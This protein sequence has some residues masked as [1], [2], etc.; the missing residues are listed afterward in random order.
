MS[1]V[2]DR[3]PRG[4]V[5]QRPISPTEW[6]YLAGARL[7]PP[8]TIQLFVEGRAGHG[9]IG[10]GTLARAVAAASAACPGAR[11]VRRGRIW[12]DSGLTPRVSRVAV[13][14]G[15]LARFEGPA[16]NQALRRQLAPKAGPSCEVLLLEGEGNEPSTLVFRA[17]HGVMDGKG[18]VAWAAEVFKAL[19]GEPSTPP[20]TEAVTDFAL[21]GRLGDTGRRPRTGVAWPPALDIRGSRPC[22]G[23]FQFRRRAVD[24]NQPGLVAKVASVLAASTG[25]TAY[26][27]MVP[28]DLRPHD[29]DLR[30]TANLT[31]PVFLDGHAGDT[32]E[33]W[34]ERL[35]KALAERTEV[36]RGQA[37]LL[38]SAVPVP[39]L[40][41][42]LQAA[43]ALARR[44][45]RYLASAV[46]SHLGRLDLAVFS[47]GEFE[48]LTIYSP[49]VHAPLVPISV[50]SVESP[51]RTELI[52]SC[53]AG[54][55]ITARAEELL[56]RITGALSP[57][58][59]RSWPG[60]QTY[61]LYRGPET[62]TQLLRERVKES[63]DAVA[64]TSPTGE[65]T[66]AQLDQRADAV[67]AELAARGLGRGAVVG[68][69]TDRSVEAVAGLW[70]TLKAGAAYLPLDPRHP[71]D[72]IGWV[73]DDAQASVCLVQRPYAERINGPDVIVLDDLPTS[74]APPA[75]P[76]TAGPRD[77]VYVIYTSGST[78]RPKGVQIEHHN[79]VNYVTWA[80]EL[81]S[82]DASTRFALFTSLAFD[83][84]GT[85][86]F[87]PLLA[88]GSVA[89]ISGELTPVTLR[90]M[91]ERSGANALKLTPAHLD[92]IGR[93]GLAPE[94]FRILVVGGE[95]LK[96]PV[97]DQAQRAFG[98]QCRIVN[99]Y[100]PTEATIGCV[101]HT[102]DPDRDAAST[103]VPIGT[104]VANTKVYLLGPDRQ[105][106]PAG[107]V[108]ELY[109]TGAQLARGYLGRPDLDRERFV[110]LVDGA[111]A[112]RTG[113]LARILPS[114]ALEC[115][116]RT[117]DQVTLRGHRVEPGEIEAVLEE[118]P[119]VARAL[120]TVRVGSGGGVLCGYVVHATGT[121]A[122]TPPDV[123]ELHE[124]LAVRLPAYMVP[125]ALISVPE[126][127][128]TV[129]GKIDV[130]ALPY[131]FADVTG[132]SGQ[133]TDAVLTP[134]L[135]KME[136]QVAEI[137][138]RLLKLD[139]ERIALDD[140]FHRLG[141]DSLALAEMFAGV[142]AEVVCGAGAEN[143]LAQ[144][145][146]MIR[147]P[148]L[149][150]V[151]HAARR[152]CGLG[153]QEVAGS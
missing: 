74:G 4:S 96:G 79:L 90:D 17:F 82:V 53:P 51:G 65:V 77:L 140:D 123:R 14:A 38:A 109:L 103:A 101:V 18:V 5:F 56:D 24:G 41:R 142:A 86:I 108:G 10:L 97:A 36:T 43:S 143:F 92:L 22:L 122:G 8:F 55:A 149:G 80:S 133:R 131:P 26:R 57:T 85:S 146:E 135:D 145:R 127:P 61:S 44:R 6:L 150:Y 39:A 40:T 106:V 95:R 42:G 81:Y 152:A 139:A 132:T 112:Y 16:L 73:L 32:W 89:L 151:C 37:E 45:N 13:P 84:T 58:A 60:N 72:R 30:S 7:A 11:L 83:L 76:G 88:G 19:R 66:Y 134:R 147:N 136:E 115:L 63:P 100:G 75:P 153:P 3:P 129:N 33:E 59:A 125:A 2:H 35:L 124:H 71:D 49:P 1:A 69:L 126:L 138:A 50:V 110:T 148:T 67:A 70:G 25:E 46:V 31:L 87:L 21:A 64:L 91:L 98:P 116:G 34:H 104:P 12:V 144:L 118:H 23:H 102:Y 105:H 68:L 141:G 117:D 54:E 114:G 121:A 111:L 99:E 9:R 48:A 47:A 107:L 20:A 113:D 94:G 128:Q 119:R 120:V 78:G 15:Q 62:V 28:V 93:L 27:F 137:W 130:Q 52:L 29:P